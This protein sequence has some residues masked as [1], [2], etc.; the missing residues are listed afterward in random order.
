MRIVYV[1]SIRGFAL[2]WMLFFQLLDMFSTYNLYG[3]HWFYVVNWVPIFFIVAGFSSNL[4]FQKYGTKRFYIKVLR[5]F[6]FFSCI[7]FFLT[8]WCGFTANSLFIF[9]RDVVGAIGLNLLLSSLLFLFSSKISN[10]FHNVLWFGFCGSIMFILNWLFPLDVIFSPFVM[11]MY[12]CFG[13][14]LAF[15]RETKILRIAHY[16][17]KIPFSKVLRYF[18]EHSLFFYFFHFAIF[19]KLLLVMNRFQTFSVAEGAFLTVSSILT[20]VI[21]EKFR[22]LLR[23]LGV[24]AYISK[25]LF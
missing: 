5:R 18:G 14:A 2:L 24:F 11:L 25:S 1:D 19:Q 6:M 10:I 12:M 23:G 21:L 8:S 7:G 17:E 20:L 9:D 13:V 4:M 22:S 3:Q 16:I 15:L